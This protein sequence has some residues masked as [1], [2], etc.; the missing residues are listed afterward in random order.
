MAKLLD[1]RR[2]LVTEANNGLANCVETAWDSTHGLE[3]TKCAPTHAID[4]KLQCI[5]HSLPN[6][7]EG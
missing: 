7:I 5:P 6:C 4:E 3:C 1:E 2:C